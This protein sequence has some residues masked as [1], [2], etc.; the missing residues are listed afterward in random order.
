MSLKDLHIAVF[1]TRGVSL[2]MWDKQGM[3]GR[4]VALYKAL[5]DHVAGITFVT[6]GTA[7]DLGYKE[8]L[9]GINIQCNRWQLPLPLYER[10][11]QSWVARRWPKS[12]LV[13][14][15]QVMGADVALEAARISKRH[16]VARCGY[17][18]SDFTR[19]KHGPES[20]ALDRARVLEQRIFSGAHRVVVTTSVMQDEV[21]QAYGVSPERIAVIPNYVQ[22][23]LFRPRDTAEIP[24]RICFIGRLEHQKNL[25]S[26]LEAVC[27]LDV[28]LVIIGSGRLRGELESDAR[29]KN[30]RAEFMGNLP[31]EN[32]PEILAGTQ[33]FVLPSHYEGHPKTLLEAMACARPVVGTRVPG[34]QELIRHGETGLL[35]GTSPEELR[36]SILELKQNPELRNR[37]GRNARA[38][39]TS[40]FSLKH[41]VE[42]ETAL[43]ETLLC[44]AKPS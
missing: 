30:L 27:S 7:A 3:L 42:L 21:A 31:H 22:T 24:D 1:F 34:I 10:L 2:Q 40:E 8:T 37:L 16:F 12:T 14:S 23:D 43:Y 32:L 13:K 5:L 19:R 15:N 11:L 29:R 28:E 9:S 25:F 41:I 17:L 44:E 18:H 20:T 38:F 35:C 26:L 39:V 36:A 33:M 6:Y 4:E